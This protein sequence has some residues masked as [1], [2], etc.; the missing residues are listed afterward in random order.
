MPVATASCRLPVATSELPFVS[1]PQL[2]RNWNMRLGASSN[3]KRVAVISATH[4]HTHICTCTCHTHLPHL[5]LCNNF[6]LELI[7]NA[8]CTQRVKQLRLLL[9]NFF[10][11]SA[12]K[13]ST[14]KSLT[15][16]THTLP[17]THCLTHTPSTHCLTFIIYGCCKLS[18]FVKYAWITLGKSF[19]G[20]FSLHV[21]VSLSLSCNL[22][23]SLLLWQVDLISKFVFDLGN[24]L[25]SSLVAAWI[26]DLSSLWHQ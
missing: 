19:S 15:K 5:W 23:H 6:Y 18:E 12:T 3:A 7:Q 26:Y 25:L 24:L 10:S 1:L 16:I 4:T 8:T 11:V 22:W 21:C 20:E 2:P 17:H 9:F 13:S 14:T